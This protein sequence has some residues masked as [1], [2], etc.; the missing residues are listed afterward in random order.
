MSLRALLAPFSASR[1]LLLSLRLLL[2]LQLQ[3]FG[4]LL[5]TFV[6]LLLNFVLL[7]LNFVLLLLNFVLLLLNFVLD[8]LVQE[9]LL[10]ALSENQHIFFASLILFNSSATIASRSS[11]LIGHIGGGLFGGGGALS[12]LDAVAPLFGG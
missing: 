6:L 12:S 3:S 2:S 7:L 1:I 4:F 10:A 8:L 11:S 5:L 9:S